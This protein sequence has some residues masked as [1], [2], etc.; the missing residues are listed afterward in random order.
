VKTCLKTLHELGATQIIQNVTFLGAAID[1]PDKEKTRRRMAEV[2]SNIV[3]GEIKNVFTA[4][5]W[6]LPMY[7]VCETD[8]AMGRSDVFTEQFLDGR[9]TNLLGEIERHRELSAIAS[10]DQRV[11]LLQNYDI[12]SLKS[13]WFLNGIGHISY[14]NN[15]QLILEHIDFHH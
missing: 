3:A 10:H 6:I 4:N 12:Y 11:F 8:L 7:M 5:D 1:K 15:L 13:S 9:R 14:K 2:F